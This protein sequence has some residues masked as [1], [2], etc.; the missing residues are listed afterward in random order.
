MDGWTLRDAAAAVLWLP[1][2]ST[3]LL[4][5]MVFNMSGIPWRVHFLSLC[6][7]ACI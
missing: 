2:F 5:C 4:L 7:G 3:R 6:A 1:A